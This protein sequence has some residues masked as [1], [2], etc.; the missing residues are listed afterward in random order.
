MAATSSRHS[1]SVSPP[2][3][4]SRSS[5]FGSVASARASSS[6]LRSSSVSEPASTLAFR[7]RP[8]SAST[9][10]APRSG[11]ALAAAAA[12]GG[13]DEHV[14]EHRHAGEGVRDLERAGDAEAA[15]LG[16]RQGA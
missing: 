7:D 14:L 2:A 10:I 15:A 3:I 8:V 11:V 9:S 6:R 5:S 13:A 1:C 12:E 16:R 4:S